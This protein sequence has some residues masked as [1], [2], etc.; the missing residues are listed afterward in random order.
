MKHVAV[1][2][3]RCLQ[4]CFYLTKMSLTLFPLFMLMFLFAQSSTTHCKS[5]EWDKK[6]TQLTPPR[7]MP[8]APPPQLVS[9]SLKKPAYQRPN[10]SQLQPK[11][12]KGFHPGKPAGPVSLAWLPLCQVEHLASLQQRVQTP[13]IFMTRDVYS[14]RS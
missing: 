9:L 6:F 12:L 5:L 8:S 7:A 2:Q 13:G 11:L 3:I 10:P 14:P 4:N 1:S